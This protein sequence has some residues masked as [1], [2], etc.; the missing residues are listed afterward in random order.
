MRSGSYRFLQDIADREHL[1][2]KKN[3]TAKEA[4]DKVCLRIKN[5]VIAGLFDEALAIAKDYEIANSISGQESKIFLNL[6]IYYETQEEK[7]AVL[8]FYQAISSDSPFYAN[9]HVKITDLNRQLSKLSLFKV[10]KAKQTDN[11]L[12]AT[13]SSAP[14]KISSP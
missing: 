11:P 14:T 1:I 8:I 13:S 12:S 7:K 4:Y 6:A 3:Q 5:R 2:E 10:E 9:A